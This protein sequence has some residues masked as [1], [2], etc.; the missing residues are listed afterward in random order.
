MKAFLSD[1]F[2]L[3]T[4]TAKVLFFD[5]AQTLPI[6]DYHCHLSP[7]MIYENRIF[8]DMSELWLEGDHYK[9]RLMRDMGVDE[10]LC[11]GNVA[12][13]DKFKAF[14][15]VLPYAIGNPLYHW[16]HLELSRY[17]DFGK[18]LS[19]ETAEEA[20]EHCNKKLQNLKPRDIISMSN[21]EIICTTDDPADDLHYHELLASDER[22]QT[23][24]LPAF[25]PDKVLAAGKPDFA[26][27]IKKLSEIAQI[28]ITNIDELK[29]ALLSRIDYFDKHGCKAADHGLTDINGAIASE[30]DAQRIFSNALSGMNITADEER[31]Y[32]LHLLCFLCAE[33]NRKNWVC[34][35]H[36]G[37][38]R[39]VNSKSYHAL[40][41]DTGFDA[42]NPEPCMNSLPK[43]LDTLERGGNLPKMLIFS[44]NPNDNAAIN[45]LTGCFSGR[46]QQGAAWWFNDTLDG[47]MSQLKVFAASHALSTHVGM[48]T[49]SRS[50]L[51]FSRHK[52]FRRIL[53]GLL[54]GWVKNG[55]YPADT[56]KLG[57]IVKNI[58]YG[59]AMK[60]FGFE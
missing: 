27:Y 46:V 30:K 15:S 3:D 47:M 6:V 40:G 23:R 13:K 39:N 19:D 17:F 7:K 49:D 22:F 21:V 24:V 16:A 55:L 43:L 18:P 31:A 10:S 42:I 36:F 20:W 60:F 52:Y 56:K 50:L 33:Y 1:D 53:C 8:K 59:N 35:L 51:S 5:V 12:G 11:T 44:I 48:L 34:E 9:W 28:N 58:C 57:E 38:I 29:T 25:R 54:G 37:V 45:I 2:L 14:A 26:E 41:A 4:E 32:R